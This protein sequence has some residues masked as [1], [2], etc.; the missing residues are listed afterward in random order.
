[1]F[2]ALIALAGLAIVSIISVFIPVKEAENCITLYMRLISRRVLAELIGIPFSLVNRG[3]LN[4]KAIVLENLPINLRGEQ[5]RS[6]IDEALSRY[7][8]LK[9]HVEVIKIQNGKIARSRFA[10]DYQDFNEPKLQQLKEMYQLDKII[11]N[12]KTDFEKALIIADW[13]RAQFRYGG[14]NA[15]SR[16]I[17]ALE[18]IERG[19]NGECFRCGSISRAFV[20]CL[21]SLGIQGRILNIAY[22]LNYA[23][24][25]PEVWTDNLGKWIVIDVDNNLHYT[26]NDVPLNAL[27][28]HNIWFKNEWERVEV[29]F[30]NSQHVKSPDISPCKKIHFYT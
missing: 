21:L 10:F 30:G 13:L 24:V 5:E 11:E 19:K 29:V 16:N 6:R 1:M 12:A 4:P 20:Q 14:P 9:E 3:S 28:L 7:V 27:E 18:I 25:V 17:N 23:H 2:Y 8:H 22:K 15:V 26:L